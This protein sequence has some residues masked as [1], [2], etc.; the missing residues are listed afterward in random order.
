MLQEPLDGLP[1]ACGSPDAVTQTYL[2]DLEDA[3]HVLDVPL[4]SRRQVLSRR[5]LPHVQC[6]PQSAEQ[7]PGDPGDDV[8]QGS[9][10]L[11]SAYLPPVLLSVEVL[12]P[13]VYAEVDRLTEALQMGGTM[14][15]L[16]LL[17]SLRL[18]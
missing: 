4:D 2:G 11:G 1:L 9:R 5:H 17:Y 8:I 12:D 7:S 15:S 16:V 3:V 14:R 10:V 6:G 13:A 18:V